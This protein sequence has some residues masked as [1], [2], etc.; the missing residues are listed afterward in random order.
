MNKYVKDI[1]TI[2]IAKNR[3]IC[4]KT[5]HIMNSKYPFIRQNKEF[6]VDV[7][8]YSQEEFK[9]IKDTHGYNKKLRLTY[10]S[11]SK[12]DFYKMVYDSAKPR[13]N[14]FGKSKLPFRRGSNLL[15]R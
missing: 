7:T 15:F 8:N 10:T 1:T 11:N 9:K 13:V 2:I 14:H 4:K 3:V 6:N 5:T 12:E